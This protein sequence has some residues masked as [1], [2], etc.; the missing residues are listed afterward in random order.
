MSG[1]D[2]VDRVRI[3]ARAMGSRG[4]KAVHLLAAVATGLA[5][6]TAGAQSL[7]TGGNVVAGSAT[8][9]QPSP[10]RLDVNQH[11]DRAVINWDSFSIGAGSRTDIRQPGAGSVSVQ[12]VIGPTPS[13]IFGTLTSNGRVVVANP[14]GVWFGPGSRID[15]AGIAATTATMSPAAIDR[16]MGGGRLEFDRPGRSDAAVV[17]DGTISVADHGLAALVAPGVANSG[18]IV[19]RLGRVELASGSRFTLDLNGDG[20]VE[21]VV[22]DEVLAHARHP[23]GRPLGAA[24]VNDGRIIADGGIVMLRAEAVKALVDSVI[25]MSGVIEA[26]AAETVGGTIVLSGGDAAVQVSGTLDASG[27]GA[28]QTGGTVKVLGGAVALRDGAL[29][30]VSGGAGG[31]TALVGGGAHGAGPE[32]RARTATV[33]AGARIDADALLQ[34]DG[35]FAVVWADG[36]TDFAGGISA[37]GGVAGGDGGFVET[38]GKERLR[39]ADGARVDTTAPH[40][41]TGDW[42][43]DPRNVT[44]AFAGAAGLGDVDAF[45]DTPST[46]VTISAA[47]INAAAANV[48]LQANTDITVSAP[49]VLANGVD[50]TMNAGRSVVLNQNVTTNGGDFTATIN[51]AGASAGDRIAGQAAFTM[52]SG[53]TVATGGGTVSISSGSFGGGGAAYVGDMTVRTINSG[54][55][56]VTIANAVG[57]VKGNPDIAAGAGSIAISGY[58]L[59]PGDLTTTGTVALTGIGSGVVTGNGAIN[60]GTLALSGA[61]TS[62]DLGNEDNTVGQLGGTVADLDFLGLAGFDVAGLTAT[63]A[64]G[65]TFTTDGTVTQSGAIS[66]T[67]DTLTLNGGAGAYV[68]D[69]TGNSVQHVAG[70]AGSVS[71]YGAGGYDVAALTSFG[72]LTL[73]GDGAVTQSGAISASGLLLRGTGSFDFSTDLNNAVTTVA[74]DT[75]GAVKLTNAGALAVGTVLGVDGV[76]AGTAELRTLAGDLSLDKRV[77][78]SG[79]GT[80]IVIA[81]AEDLVNNY[82]A[83]AL[84]AGGGRWLA[85]TRNKTDATFNNLDSGNSAIWNATYASTAPAAVTQSG[86]RYLIATQPTV[87]FVAA[88]LSKVYGDD[89]TGALASSYTLTG[90][91]PGIANVYLADTAATSYSGAPSLTSAGT[92]TRAAVAGSPYAIG[93]TQNTVAGINGYAIGSFTSTAGLTVTAKPLTAALAGSVSK[94]YDGGTDATLAAGN[95][96]LPGVVAGDTVTLN[97]PA[98]GSYDSKTAGAGKT[99]TVNGLAIAGADSGNYTLTGTSVS[100]AVGTITQAPLTVSG[101]TANDKVYDR[102]TTATLATGGAVLAGIIGTDTVTLDASGY[103]ASFADRNAGAGKAVTVTGLGLDGADGG[104]YALTQPAGLTAE[105]TRAP[106]TVTGVTAGDKVYDT[107]RT[108]TLGTAGAGLSGVYAGDTVTLDTSG[109]SALFADKNVGIAKPVTVAGMAIGGA[110]GGNYALSQPAGLTAAITPAPATVSGVTA[111]GRVYDGTTGA[112]L[113]TGAATLGGV[114]A[115]DTVTLDASGYAA[116]F[117]DKNAGVAKA[118]TVTGLGLSGADGTN[119]ALAQPAG[120]TATITPA[121]VTATGITADDKTYDRTTTAT[122]STGGAGLSGTVAG[123][124]VS[125]DTSGYAAEFADRNAGSGRA[126]TV[127]GMA[128]SGADRGNYTLAQPAGLTATINQAPLTVTGVTADDKTYDATR[129][130]TLA[131]AGA[132]LSGVIAGDTVTL[133]TGSYAAQFADKNAGAGKAVTVSGMTIGGADSTNYALAQPAGLTATISTASLTVSGVTADDKI[134]DRGT[135]TSLS[136]GAAS[137]TGVLPGDTVSLDTSSYSAN[138]ADR[139]AGDDKPVTVAGLRAGGAD[140]GNYTLAQPAGLTADIA[141]APLTVN[142]VTVSDKVYDRSTTAT[143][144]AAGAT[145]SGVIA[146]DTVTLN[147]AGAAGSFADKNVGVGKAVTVTGLLL[148]GADGGNYVLTQ[149]A[150]LTATITAAPL[151]VS[152]VRANDRI[153]DATTT[154]TLNTGGASLSGVLAG[155]T[156]SL[157][158]GGYTASFADKYVGSG[159]AVTVAGLVLSGPDG[160]NYVLSQ[161]GGLTATITPAPVTAGGISARDKVYDGG[162]AASLSTSGDGVSGALAGDAVGIDAAGASGSFADKNVGTGKTVTVTGLVLTGADKSNY[163]LTQPDGVTASITPATVTV[164]GVTAD[165]KVYD[166]TTAATLSTSGAALTGVLGSDV[167]S[168]YDGGYFADFADKNAG[169]AKPVTVT[170]LVLAGADAGNY[171]L[172]QPSGLSAD[173]TPAPLT[174]TAADASMRFGGPMPALTATYVGFKGSDTEAVVTGLRLTTLASET[175]PAGTYAIT[176]GGATAANYTITYVDGTLTVTAVPVGG[177]DPVPASLQAGAPVD[178]AGGAGAAPSPLLGVGAGAVPRAGGDASGLLRLGWISPFGEDYAGQ[179]ANGFANGLLDGSESLPASPAPLECA[180]RADPSQEQD[181][182]E[183]LSVAE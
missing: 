80:A 180:R 120:L 45:G 8:I 64:G 111:N 110:D 29:L 103:A 75:S 71:F 2:R 86:N 18:V 105:I 31:G 166:A 81:P 172:V 89:G 171:V 56:S 181:H 135:A 78:A 39:V 14:N 178:P 170:G 28:G 114:L 63:G 10:T 107:T 131:T 122:L 125:L 1:V 49:I 61:S 164:S 112:S 35:G 132:G 24:V 60:A 177:V 140:G 90:L 138:F 17:N 76:G 5:P 160:G 167:V 36:L 66:V 16:F 152:G 58:N 162:T 82:G 91:D 20:L 141:P 113:S 92:A 97:N 42:L 69:N 77:S 88:D 116:S 109:H 155:D 27:D 168:L 30:D 13:Q 96:S 21:M 11:S 52:Q 137:F 179:Q 62:F 57:D 47:T 153:Y 123:D 163:V 127:T 37:R 106:L 102:T 183:C 19:A 65:V 145:V 148:S 7:P 176:P 146:G 15:V 50:L 108:A 147:T 157:G 139:N 54:G 119:Y 150:G 117:A 174:I 128:L 149:P 70:T 142:G 79:A 87:S 4:K 33:S 94:V 67:A 6:A 74:A 136:T 143:V 46:D 165:D 182:E 48:T 41:R 98:A 144:S 99:V 72:D 59:Q 101:V 124:L 53:R 175:S 83:G 161:P 22:G 126:V 44:V 159:K 118:V 73:A 12:Q 34:G 100:G 129:T 104:N 154:A 55:G 9:S 151:T 169:T 130:A 115:G 173:I 156:V 51:D 38:S 43:L 3:S 95:Y 32:P 133:D 68:L 158:T 85:Y 84:S 93:I 134:Y 25:D 23:D 121:A 40:G 26:R